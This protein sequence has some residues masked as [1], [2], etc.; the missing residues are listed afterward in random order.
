MDLPSGVQINAIKDLA[1]SFFLYKKTKND[2]PQS[3]VIT[4]YINDPASPSFADTTLNRLLEW[5]LPSSDYAKISS[6]TVSSYYVNNTSDTNIYK[7]LLSEAILSAFERNAIDDVQA[8]NTIMPTIS[9]MFI[10]DW[11]ET[12]LS[13]NSSIEGVFQQRNRVYI[14]LSGGYQ[15]GN[16]LDKKCY[17]FVVKKN[18]DTTEPP[19]PDGLGETWVNIQL[20]Q[21]GAK[22]EITNPENC[23]VWL[24]IS[25]NYIIPRNFSVYHPI[26][27]DDAIN[28]KASSFHITS[29]SIANLIWEKKFKKKQYENVSSY[30]TYDSLNSYAVL[31]GVEEEISGFSYRA[32]S[33]DY[34]KEYKMLSSEYEDLKY[35]NVITSYL[36]GNK[37]P[38]GFVDVITGSIKNSTED[39]N[40][41]FNLNTDDNNDAYVID[42]SH[43]ARLDSKRYYTNLSSISKIY[44]DDPENIK[45]S[46]FYYISGNAGRMEFPDY[47]RHNFPTIGNLV[48]PINKLELK[49]QK[50][51]R[52]REV[53]LFNVSGFLGI[54]SGKAYPNDLTSGNLNDLH[55]WVKDEIENYNE[56][57]YVDLTNTCFGEKYFGDVT[58]DS[59]KS[60]FTVRN[61]L[62]TRFDEELSTNIAYSVLDE[63]QRPLYYGNSL[64]TSAYDIGINENPS[65]KASP[66][67]FTE[68]NDMY[69]I[70]ICWDA[71]CENPILIHL[72]ENKTPRL[73]IY[74]GFNDRI[75]AREPALS[76]VTYPENETFYDWHDVNSY[77]AYNSLNAD[78]ISTA[79]MSAT[80]TP[81]D[82]TSAVIYD[83]NSASLKNNL[84]SISVYFKDDAV[85]KTYRIRNNDNQGK[86]STTL[87]EY[88]PEYILS[89]EDDD[90]TVQKMKYKALSF[91]FKIPESGWLDLDDEIYAENPN[92]GHPANGFTDSTLSSVMFDGYMNVLYRNLK[93]GNVSQDG[94]VTIDYTKLYTLSSVNI[95]IKASVRKP[96]GAAINDNPVNERVFAVSCP[97]NESLNFNA[98]LL[99]TADNTFEAT[100]HLSY[101]SFPITLQDDAETMV[102]LNDVDLHIK[103]EEK[104]SGNN[105]SG[106][107][108]ISPQSNDISGFT[109]RYKRS[110]NFANYLE[111]GSLLNEDLINPPASGMIEA[112]NTSG[113]NLAYEYALYESYGIWPGKIIDADVSGLYL[114]QLNMISSILSGPSS[115]WIESYK[116]SVDNDGTLTA[117]LSPILNIDNS[118]TPID[119]SSKN[120]I[121]A[122]L[123]LSGANNNVKLLSAALS[124]L[125]KD[126][127][128]ATN[129]YISNF[130]HDNMVYV[131]ATKS[132]L[133]LFFG[134][135]LE[136]NDFNF[137]KNNDTI[138]FSSSAL[139]KINNLENTVKNLFP[140]YIS[141]DLA[142]YAFSRVEI[143]KSLRTGCPDIIDRVPKWTTSH[144]PFL[145]LIYNKSK[146]PD[147]LLKKEKHEKEFT[148]KCILNYA[149]KKT[150]DVCPYQYKTLGNIASNATDAAGRWI[151]WIAL[152]DIRFDENRNE[153]TDISSS[154]DD[155][156]IKDNCL[157]GKYVHVPILD[158][159]RFVSPFDIS[160]NILYLS[161]SN[162]SLA[163]NAK[164]M[165]SIM[166]PMEDKPADENLQFSFDQFFDKEMVLTSYIPFGYWDRLYTYHDSNYQYGTSLDANCSGGTNTAVLYTDFREKS[167]IYD[168]YRIKPDDACTFTSV[169]DISLTVIP[170][171]GNMTSLDSQAAFQL[172]VKVKISFNDLCLKKQRA[173]GVKFDDTSKI[174]FDKALISKAGL[175]GSI[176]SARWGLTSGYAA[177]DN[178]RA[179]DFNE[180]HLGDT[181]Y[182]FGGSKYFNDV[183]RMESIGKY[184]SKWTTSETYSKPGEGFEVLY[185]YSPRVN[186]NRIIGT[187]YLNLSGMISVTVTGSIVNE[188]DS[189]KLR[190]AVMKFAKY[191]DEEVANV[192]PISPSLRS[193]SIEFADSVKDKLVKNGYLPYDDQKWQKLVKINAGGSYND[194]NNQPYFSMLFNSNDN[195]IE[196]Q[197]EPVYNND[198]GLLGLSVQ[199]KIKGLKKFESC[200]YR[201]YFDNPQEVQ[202][203]SETMLNEYLE[204]GEF[205]ENGYEIEGF[206]PYAKVGDFVQSGYIKCESNH[207]KLVPFDNRRSCGSTKYRYNAPSKNDFQLET[208]KWSEGNCIKNLYYVNLPVGE[209]YNMTLYHIISGANKYDGSKFDSIDISGLQLTKITGDTIED[210]PTKPTE[211]FST[212]TPD[213]GILQGLKQYN[214]A[215]AYPTSITPSSSQMIADIYNDYD[216]N[217]DPCCRSEFTNAHFS[218][219]ASAAILSDNVTAEE[220][221]KKSRTDIITLSSL[222]DEFN[223]G[224]KVKI[225]LFAN[226]ILSSELSGILKD[227]SSTDNTAYIPYEVSNYEGSG[228]K[229][230]SFKLRDSN[231]HMKVIPGT[232]LNSLMW[233]ST[234]N[235]S[236]YTGANEI[237]YYDTYAAS[238]NKL[239]EY[240]K[241]F[242]NM[243]YKL[244]PVALKRRILNSNYATMVYNACEYHDK[245]KSIRSIDN[246]S[247]E[248]FIVNDYTE[249]PTSVAYVWNNSQVT[250]NETFEIVN[251]EALAAP[252]Y[253][254]WTESSEKE[255]VAEV[256]SIYNFRDTESVANFV[257]NEIASISN[258]Q[259]TQ[260]P[261]IGSPLAYNKKS[262]DEGIVTVNEKIITTAAL[263]YNVNGYP[264]NSVMIYNGSDSVRIDNNFTT[265]LYISQNDAKNDCVFGATQEK[266][267]YVDTVS[268]NSEAASEKLK[269]LKDFLLEENF[270]D[271]D[272]HLKEYL[273]VEANSI[274]ANSVPA[275][276]T[277]LVSSMTSSTTI[278]DTYLVNYV[279]CTQKRESLYKYD[280]STLEQKEIE[281]SYYLNSLA[282]YPNDTEYN[283][284]KVFLSLSSHCLSTLNCFDYEGNMIEI[285]PT[286]EEKASKLK[287]I[288]G[289]PLLESDS[290]FKSVSACLL[291]ENCEKYPAAAI[292]WSEFAPANLS[293]E[294][295]VEKIKKINSQ[296][297]QTVLYDE[298]KSINLSAIK[299]V[300]KSDHYAAGPIQLG[301]KFYNVDKDAKGNCKLVWQSDE[302]FDWSIEDT[303]STLY[304]AMSS[305]SQTF[306]HS[307]VGTDTRTMNMIRNVH[308]IMIFIKK[309]GKQTDTYKPC[310]IDNIQIYASNLLN[311]YGQAYA[312]EDAY[313]KK[314]DANCR[315]FYNMNVKEYAWHIPLSSEWN[316]ILAGYTGDITNDMIPTSIKDAILKEGALTGNLVTPV[317][318]DLS[319]DGY[320]KDFSLLNTMY[321]TSPVD[322]NEMTDIISDNYMSENENMRITWKYVD[323]VYIYYNTFSTHARYLLEKN[324]GNAIFNAVKAKLDANIKALNTNSAFA[325]KFVYSGGIAIDKRENIPITENSTVFEWT[326]SDQIKKDWTDVHTVMQHD[327]YGTKVV[328]TTGSYVTTEYHNGKVH[329]TANRGSWSDVDTSLEMIDS[330]KTE[331]IETELRK[332][333]TMYNAAMTGT[334]QKTVTINPK[335]LSASA[336]LSSY[337]PIMIHYRID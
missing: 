5:S 329:S 183:L 67:G 293:Y 250:R 168:L 254:Y 97:T 120:V 105:A 19:L 228:T 85:G 252:S 132:Q 93:T 190:G 112:V 75:I 1:S 43:V 64:L 155:F 154:L 210:V 283:N 128:K 218:T 208:I 267:I 124:G 303:Y 139:K 27:K 178:Y 310:I 122:K 328:T 191:E 31:T 205:M 195:P 45:N 167:K 332:K 206:N 24:Q 177:D 2:D 50:F 148:P 186:N 221:Q 46:V 70:P 174:T 87:L 127:A 230:F 65:L 181:N 321:V 163:I 130:E 229:Q 62:G 280:E 68:E 261:V 222:L 251:G 149:L 265:Y 121:Y 239:K 184:V 6:Y 39:G 16:D 237:Q 22:S 118:W 324:Y 322:D 25:K 141:G 83:E 94:D 318:S 151:N 326:S 81:T 305:D 273:G 262:V 317:S 12:L 58:Y 336:W 99:S 259:I 138:Y 108:W 209:W 113:G 52:D 137:I 227:S 287:K 9:G 135:T 10:L 285:K 13:H 69:H 334:H 298:F 60:Q 66:I 160:T 306:V 54:S 37:V 119:N 220:A 238:L 100:R 198:G 189:Y 95:P 115:G 15:Y 29:G 92:Y 192:K 38:T 304:D 315:N 86:L 136:G 162:Q 266:P 28:P 202:L 236:R 51:E 42:R 14:L 288:I 204:I 126:V 172:P 53:H 231:Y 91:N 213:E 278:A 289:K 243:Q 295:Y 242:G 333:T 277:G 291:S 219:E 294:E 313:V 281:A 116:E 79:T 47:L 256:G 275:L 187:P 179:I 90:K 211:Y 170:K 23:K 185:D 40:L 200:G 319:F 71:A 312:I 145:R 201:Y 320:G 147:D 323:Y 20:D 61:K 203:T 123:E 49:D 207:L 175:S 152:G 226:G 188:T 74:G 284:H 263:G 199:I 240:I 134:G 131:H 307:F 76:T 164:K 101:L 80:I 104:G 150:L 241:M 26:I 8:D 140:T 176:L 271:D 166:D 335:Y 286:D 103:Y 217:L 182:M 88:S 301:F 173:Y 244:P 297:V 102:Q 111:S 197:V 129:N 296:N 309:I 109:Y 17:N 316:K 165:N 161:G 274:A 264:M 48:K 55:E 193:F 143:K 107:L 169:N 233:I 35:E 331:S 337:S 223:P 73:Y 4:S 196:S 327:T 11:L 300:V 144:R 63:Q 268:V 194:S 72:N 142:T 246:E 56:Q 89:P 78:A 272:P 216:L 302:C 156:A 282:D 59:S 110:T 234:P 249:D 270:Y 158:K 34:I 21:T 133:H 33:A 258:R 180:D 125:S 7:S 36:S 41:I 32:T 214:N 290:F 311:E 44:S 308:G 235:L 247:K 159:S 330:K 276:V 255:Y 114:D 260:W 96:D 292:I 157:T 106:T 18:N 325:D 253:L 224:G 3:S 225:H 171:A 153:S 248:S 245:S 314:A 215:E 146:I 84:K 30:F 299:I 57:N 269:F 117:N 257:K 279:K 77:I 232:Q 212:Y 82:R 98:S